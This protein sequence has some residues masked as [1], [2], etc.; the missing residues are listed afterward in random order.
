MVVLASVVYRGETFRLQSS[1]RY[2]QSA[3]RDGS[4]RLLH[5]RIW[6][7][8]HGP[9]PT[10]GEI[11]HLDH[12][13]ANNDTSNLQLRF[14]GEHQRTHMLVR[15]RDPVFRA[16]SL[17]ALAVAITKAPAWHRSP[18]GRAW[19]R[20]HGKAS[21]RG[22]VAFRVAC[23]RCASEFLAHFPTRARFC[24]RACEQRGCYQRQRTDPRICLHCGQAFLANKYRANR[25]CGYR[26]SNASRGTNENL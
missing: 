11:H 13:W 25:Y 14:S 4:E 6:S 12:D 20:A 26:C 9:I 7:D 19:H 1:G 8:T 22:R 2:Y 21:W 15:H 3:R 17:T 16:R 18:E 23:T 24:S 5:R 10:G